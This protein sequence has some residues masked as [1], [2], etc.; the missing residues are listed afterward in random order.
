M[1]QETNLVVILEITVGSEKA[2][3]IKIK[4]IR[5]SS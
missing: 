4:G 3:L 2:R 1:V 5:Q